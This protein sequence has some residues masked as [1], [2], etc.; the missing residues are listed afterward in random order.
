MDWYDLIRQF[1]GKRQEILSPE[2]L[3]ERMGPFFLLPE[4]Q[5]EYCLNGYVV[6]RSV[7]KDILTTLAKEALTLQ[8]V[9]SGS[10][11]YS[12]MA[13]DNDYNIALHDRLT[14]VA[15]TV[16]AGL[17][18]G[19]KLYSS[20][21]LV[22]PADSPEEMALHQ[23]WSFTIESEYV[24]IT[25]WI[26][27]QDVDE[28]NGAVFLLPYSHLVNPGFRSHTLPTARIAREGTIGRMT[29]IAEM[30][31]GDLLLFNPAIFHG[32]CGNTTPQHRV[33]FTTTV[34]PEA[35]PLIYADRKEEDCVD[36]HYLDDYAF[37]TQLSAL[38]ANGGF[39]GKSSK[40]LK[41]KH[42]VPTEEELY[43]KL[44]AFKKRHD[45]KG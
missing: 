31:K 45:V 42:H 28:K 34:L 29:R 20:T 6:I 13:H 18:R 1:V 26:P 41:Y 36:I 9:H 16:A 35:A 43:H 39:T 32:S 21:Y 24:P 5:E 30:K 11:Y 23:D 7:A 37:V 4:L 17:F 25:M 14:T 22:K 8:G 38:E 19:Y 27:L 40:R 15:D 2:R 12:T 10:F 44:M 3:Y 33:V